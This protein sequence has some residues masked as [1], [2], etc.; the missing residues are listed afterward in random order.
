MRA[1]EVLAT[2]PDPGDRNYAA[3]LRGQTALINTLITTRARIDETRLKEK[4]RE[5]RRAEILSRMKTFKQEELERDK[6]D[7][8]LA[9][10]KGWC[11]DSLSDKTAAAIY[12]EKTYPWL[13]K[14]HRSPTGN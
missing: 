8:R 2:S 3:Q 14:P 13:G 11:D 5:D 9:R 1:V 12:R 6:E 7:A 4:Q 10:E